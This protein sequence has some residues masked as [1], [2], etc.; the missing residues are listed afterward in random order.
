MIPIVIGNRAIG[1]GHPGFII[2][3]AGV[4]HNGDLD[5]AKKLVDVA[6]DAGADAV[7][8]QTFDAKRL[9]SGAAQKAQYQKETTT[10]DESQFEMLQQLQLSYQAHRELKTYCAQGGVLFMSTPFDEGSVDF[11]DDLGLEIFKTSSGDLTNLPLLA[12]IARK[13]KPMIVSTGMSTLQEVDAAVRAV[14]DT[15]NQQL[16]L[17]HCVSNY[18]TNPADVNLRAMHTL[19]REFDL[20]VGFSDHT[21]G[22][23]IAIASV[24]LGAVVLEKHFTLDRNLPGPDH[25][26]S[27]EPH[28][29]AAMISSIRRVEAA[30]GNGIKQPVATERPIA[31]VGRR[32]LHWNVALSEGA[33][34]AREH[35]IALR[36][37]TGISPARITDFVGRRLCRPV[38]P[39][40]MV[41]EDDFEKAQ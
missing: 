36:P 26:A 7:K 1:P 16:V 38:Q 18:P 9:V 3:E 22:V 37:G 11:L 15:G 23:D 4:N 12:H 19:A 21:T 6:A 20:P 29:L 28:E 10:A 25:Q 5:L 2:A 17:L 8:F 40:V 14:R 24:A 13:A 30:L 32:S 39:G 33:I 34:I 35:L 31:D 41:A 27:L